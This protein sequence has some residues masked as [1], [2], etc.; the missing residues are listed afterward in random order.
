MPPKFLIVFFVL[1]ALIST[2]HSFEILEVSEGSV[3][4]ISTYIEGKVENWGFKKVFFAFPEGWT[5]NEIESYAKSYMVM[6]SGLWRKYGLPT[7]RNSLIKKGFVYTK[8][9][10]YS[11]AIVNIGDRYGFW[12]L[13]NEGVIFYLKFDNIGSGGEIDPF[14][15][16]REYSGI[17][18]VRWYQSF[19]LTVTKPGIIKA[20]WVVKGAK[21]V[22]ASPAPYTDITRFSGKKK[23]IIDVNKNYYSSDAEINAPDWQKLFDGFDNSLVFWL[24]SGLISMPEEEFRIEVDYD[25]VPQVPVWIVDKTI[26]IEYAY[27]WKRYEAIEG[28]TFWRDEL[29]APSWWELF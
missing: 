16:E 12:L 3:G 28:I 23:Y 10:L 17:R 27:E 29:K 13:P 19:K 2:C 14:A 21:L 5:P 1:I 26:T 18:V 22:E 11:K 20:P 7:D 4:S 24:K 9:G 8:K 15:I 6:E 25:I